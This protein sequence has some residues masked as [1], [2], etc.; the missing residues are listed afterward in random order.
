[1]QCVWPYFKRGMDIVVATLLLVA[2]MPLF[3][4]VAVAV[5]V[6]LGTPIW[7]REQRAGLAGRPFP[8][9]KFRSMTEARDPLGHPLPDDARLGAFGRWLRRTSIDELPQLI[10]VVKGDMS[11][12]GPRPLPLRYVARYNPR[13]ARRLL[14][15]PGLTGWAQIHGRN[16]LAWPE[17]FELDA[18]YVDMM[19][20]WYAPA[21]D[22]W[23]IASTMVQLSRQAITGRG[24]SAVGHASMPEFMP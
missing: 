1:M 6:A 24:I 5:R 7:Y 3:C 14:V 21:V 13:Q 16:A 11:L 22:A 9:T 10:S 18:R 15:R 12:V 2:L 23:I 20:R 17:R 8:I 19:G 4:L